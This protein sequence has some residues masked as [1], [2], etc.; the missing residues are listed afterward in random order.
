MIHCVVNPPVRLLALSVPLAAVMFLLFPRVPGP[1][2]A[3]PQVGGSG[4]TGLSD[5]MSPG[6]ISKLVRSEAVA[7]RV[8]FFGEPPP[9]AARYWRGPVLER[10]DGRTWS[11]GIR[12]PLKNGAIRY[13]GSDPEL[14]AE[15]FDP[16]NPDGPAY[17]PEG[18][19]EGTM[20]EEL[21]YGEHTV[22]AVYRDGV[23][24]YTLI[25]GDVTLEVMGDG[26]G[27]S[28]DEAAVQAFFEA[29]PDLAEVDYEALEGG[30]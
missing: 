29:L 25:E 1:F 15:W 2:W 19:A 22:Y 24:V 9:P 30:E 20:A 7:F 6:S 10:F 14:L 12:Y 18:R 4:S 17:D 21:R 16:D 3:L 23:P 27:Q 8:S 28:P 11:E 13:P 26:P 5:S